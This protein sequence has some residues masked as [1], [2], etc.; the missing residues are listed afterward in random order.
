M[1]ETIAIVTSC[2]NYGRYLSDWADSIIK[3]TRRSDV[4]C[5][6][7]DASTDQTP[8]FVTKAASKLLAAGI[9][10]RTLRIEERNFGKARNAAVRLAGDVTW[11]QHLDCDDMAMPHMLDDWAALAP[12]ADVVAIGYERVGDLKSGPSNRTKVYKSSR[13][14]STL[15]SQCPASGVS[16]FRREFWERRPYVEDM[17]GGWDTA[18][19]IGFGHLNARFVATRRPGFMY[20]QHGDSIFNRRRKHER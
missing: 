1:N 8:D 14:K 11:V 4:V 9:P 13:G 17:N 16:P 19:W 6:V 18:L 12:T 3:L 5:I 2:R 7:D 20:R 15:E 10:T